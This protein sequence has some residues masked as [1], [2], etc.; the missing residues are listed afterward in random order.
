VGVNG[1]LCAEASSSERIQYRLPEMHHPTPE[2]IEHAITRARRLRAESFW[3]AVDTV[4]N[5]LACAFRGDA[6]KPAPAQGAAS[7]AHAG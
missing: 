7:N 1:T 2:E 6:H 4:G 3:R 5:G